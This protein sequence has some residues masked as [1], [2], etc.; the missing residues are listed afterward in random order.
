M[1]GNPVHDPVR[2]I[3]ERAR[4]SFALDVALDD[5]NRIAQV[6]SGRLDEEHRAACAHV[7]EAAMVG[8]PEPY[9]VVVTTN[10]GYPLDQNLYQCVKGLRAAAGIVREGGT[11]ILVAACEDGLP[12]HGRY[13]QLL[14]SASGPDAFLDALARGEISERDQWQV[15][16]QAEIQ[17]HARVL[18]HTPRV[19]REDLRRAWLEPVD[20]VE[21]ALR[22]AIAS[23][24]PGARAAILPV[25]PQTIAYLA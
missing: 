12:S 5:E 11:I 25:G 20:D 14:A 21:A 4:V 17:S 13:A 7:R 1:D 6:F 18:A 16:V 10:S 9:D 24:G 2:E 8:V 23:A 3:A 19:A 15:Q 22:D